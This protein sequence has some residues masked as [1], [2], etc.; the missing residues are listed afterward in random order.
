MNHTAPRFA[1]LAIG[2]GSKLT[3][4]RTTYTCTPETIIQDVEEY[5]IAAILDSKIARTRPW[6]Y[7]KWTG[8]LEPT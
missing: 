8:Y 2:P 5:E 4:P 6:Y 7:I 1:H 3:G